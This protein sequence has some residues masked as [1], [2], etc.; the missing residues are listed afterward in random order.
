VESEAVS[1]TGVFQRGCTINE[2]HGLID[3]MF[4]PDVGEKRASNHVRTRRLKLCMEYFVRF[5]TDSSVQSVL[6]VIESDHGFING[7]VIRTP[8][9]LGL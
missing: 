4:L 8:S 3:I 5:W 9:R 1:L 7:N 2:K 6:L